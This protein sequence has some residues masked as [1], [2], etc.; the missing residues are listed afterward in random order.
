[1]NVNYQIYHDVA[2]PNLSSSFILD[3]EKIEVPHYSNLCLYACR[4]DIEFYSAD[5]FDQLN[6]IYPKHIS[7]AVCGES[8]ISAINHCVTNMA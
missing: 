4:Y 7:H 6:I 5:L 8:L 3:Y 1:M 2:S